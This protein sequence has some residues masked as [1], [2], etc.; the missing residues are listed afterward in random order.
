MASYHHGNL[1]DAILAAAAVVIASDG[2]GALSLRAIANELWVSHTAFRRHF[3]NR[4]GVLNALA[5]QGN[6]RL[7]Q[8]LTAAAAQGDFVD[9]GVAYVRFA[10]DHPGHFTVMF[11]SDLLDN[12]DPELVAAR[13]EAFAPLVAGVA[14]KGLDDPEAGQVLGWSVV[15]GIATLALTGNLSSGSDVESVARRAIA[16]TYPP[17]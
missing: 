5:V 16:L 14:A 7:A 11:R 17:S 1:R 9:V 4:E 3:G 8:M 15:H 13:A 10:L 6:R 2:V 12:A